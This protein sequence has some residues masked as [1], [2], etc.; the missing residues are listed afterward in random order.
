VISNLDLIFHDRFSF[1]LGIPLVIVVLAH[2][3]V[4]H[5]IFLRE[6]DVKLGYSIL[7]MVASTL[8]FVLYARKAAEA[9]KDVQTTRLTLTLITL[10][11]LV[12]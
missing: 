10:E 7:E 3:T 6:I 8:V 11:Q 2:V 5:G 4:E 12:E 9:S 1:A